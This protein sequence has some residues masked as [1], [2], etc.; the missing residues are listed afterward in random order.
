MTGAP[1]RI[2]IIRYVMTLLKLFISIRSGEF[3]TVGV[4]GAPGRIRTCDL[5]LRRPVLYPAELRAHLATHDPR[6]HED[7]IF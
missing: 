2:V 1:G 3:E 7:G 5:R 6:Q 4:F